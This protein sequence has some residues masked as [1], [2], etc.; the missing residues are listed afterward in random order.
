MT[1]YRIPSKILGQKKVEASSATEGLHRLREQGCRAVSLA[2][3]Q[4]WVGDHWAFASEIPTYLGG[5]RQEEAR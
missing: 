5:Y 4:V 1:T 3:I 2:N